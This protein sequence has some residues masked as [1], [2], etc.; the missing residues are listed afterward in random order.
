MADYRLVSPFANIFP[1][2]LF[3]AFVGR[4]EELSQMNSSLRGRV[5]GIIL[6]GMPGVGKTS[7]ARMY[8][9]RHKTNFPGGVFTVSASWF[10]SSSHLLERAIEKPPEQPSLLIIDDAEVLRE[11]GFQPILN[12]LQKYPDLKV[13]LTSRQPLEIGQAFNTLMLDGFT[14]EEFQELA[15]LRLAVAEGRLDSNLVERLF[16]LAGGNPALLSIAIELVKNAAV[17]SWQELFQYLRN[18][19]AP[20]LIGLDGQPLTKESDQYKR[21]IIDVSSANEEILQVLKKNPEIVWKLPPRKFE[22]IVADILDRQGYEVS[23]TPASGDG[24][25][26]IYA[27]RKEG[28]GRFLFLVECKRY[29][30]PNKVGVEIVR[31]L[32]GVLQAKRATAG[33]IV[34]TSFFTAGAEAFQ[35]EMQHQLHLHDYI[36][37]QK[38]M[39]DF[40]LQH[41]N[42][43]V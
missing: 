32:Y 6:L 3:S 19:Q 20:G 22:E 27:A 21:I 18:F 33:A 28:L 2:D 10:E 25:F 41:N 8:A 40:P 24:G 26:D 1:T 13:I 36:A 42:D 37:L 43:T 34:T 16:Q 31:S 17:S 30:P 15:S 29:V 39:T 7:L 5:R 12:A 23:L 35:R 38:W 9:E 11:E 4:Q 14:R